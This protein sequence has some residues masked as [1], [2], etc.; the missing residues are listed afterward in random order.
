[1]KIAVD[2]DGT[3]WN[4]VQAAFKRQGLSNSKIMEPFRELVFLM[5]EV[6]PKKG[7]VCSYLGQIR[8]NFEGELDNGLVK[9]LAGLQRKH[10]D[11][12][13]VVRTSNPK[14]SEP[15]MHFIKDVLASNGLKVSGVEFKPVREKGIGVD[16]V[17][18]DEIFTSVAASGHGAEVVIVKRNYNKLSG[19]A[20]SMVNRHVH[21]VETSKVAKVLER[22][23]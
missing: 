18:G 10:S 22:M 16:A 23:M 7:L 11:L 9:E 3:L 17:L 21:Y 14:V 12:E 6:F 20:L 8:E 2:N 15:D 4:D 1:V 13:I 19:T 5:A